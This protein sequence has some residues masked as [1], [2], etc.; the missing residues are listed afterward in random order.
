MI[1]DPGQRMARLLEVRLVEVI[2]G[3]GRSVTLSSVRC[4]VRGRS[5]AVEACVECGTA[6]GIAQDALARGD[7]V[8][9]G[10]RER[11]AVVAGDGVVVGVLA[12]ADVIAW[13]AQD[14]AAV[15]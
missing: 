1:D 3:R 8:C 9:C 2:S 5:A 11:L 12:A 14:G 6:G 15:V 7:Y 4:P 13:L 10:A